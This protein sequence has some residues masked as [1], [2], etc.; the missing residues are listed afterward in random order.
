M[1]CSAFMGI[2]ET[3]EVACMNS[4]TVGLEFMAANRPDLYVAGLACVETHLL[5]QEVSGQ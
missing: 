4:L 1:Q 5:D 3:T 2:G